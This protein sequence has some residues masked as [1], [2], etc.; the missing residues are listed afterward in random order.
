[1]NRNVEYGQRTN[2][3]SASGGIMVA[4]A[5]TALQCSIIRDTWL[6]KGFWFWRSFRKRQ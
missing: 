2:A 4:V 6:W 5:E 3:S 1:M